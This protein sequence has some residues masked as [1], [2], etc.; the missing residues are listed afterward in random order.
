MIK[1]SSVVVRWLINSKAILPDDKETYEYAVFC[2]LIT[3]TPLTLSIVIGAL[4][5]IFW[6]SI[7]FILP[8]IISRKFSGG[9]HFKSSIICIIFSTA[10]IALFLTLVKLILFYQ[11]NLNFL[12]LSLI[13]IS[14]IILSVFSPIDSEERKLSEKEK[15]VFKRIVIGLGVIFLCIY[16]VLVL[17]EL[18]RISVP[19]SLGVILTAAL[20]IPCIILRYKKNGHKT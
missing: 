12:L 20:Q 9:F 7:F 3:A 2:F 6:E 5:G 14:T 16:S 15:Y 19:F 11:V 8:F 18:Y 10:T 4:L 17:N 13:I 1:I